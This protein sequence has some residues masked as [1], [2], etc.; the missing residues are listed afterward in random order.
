MTTLIRNHFKEEIKKMLNNFG[1]AFVISNDSNVTVERNDNIF[2]VSS[3]S[4]GTA[5]SRTAEGAIEMALDH[6]VLRKETIK[7]II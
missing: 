6:F 5:Y 3:E 1:T 2:A 7:S 4:F